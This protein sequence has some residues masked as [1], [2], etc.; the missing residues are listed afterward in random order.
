MPAGRPT[1]S[2]ESAATIAAKAAKKRTA[3]AEAESQ[4]AAK[5]M[6]FFTPRTRSSA[7]SAAAS[8]GTSSRSSA[9]AS[10]S[11]VLG[12]DDSKP[13][14]LP[15]SIAGTGGAGA[16]LAADT[17]VPSLPPSMLGNSSAAASSSSAPGA[18]DGAPPTLPSPIAGAGGAGAG[19]ADINM[20]VQNEEALGGLRVQ[21]NELVEQQNAVLEQAPAP[22]DAPSIP[23]VPAA[24][25]TPETP[26]APL[27]PVDAD[28]DPETAEDTPMRTYLRLV[29]QRLMKE[30]SAKSG[31]T[32]KWL[33]KL[34]D[35]NDW[36][37]RAEHALHVCSKLGIKEPAERFYYYSVYVWLPDVRWGAVPSCLCGCDR[38]NVISHGFRTGALRRGNDEWGGR[39]HENSINLPYF[40]TS[41]Q[42]FRV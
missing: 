7:N 22:A 12:M 20:V 11:S 30:M 9:T 24:P 37:L 39:R 1:G 29:N 3:Q 10:S 15:L 18:G 38:K 14:V 6:N 41:Q 13:P 5:K 32:D 31:W 16:G 21:R 36:W 4:R 27:E 34:L 35:H 26:E 19:L 40:F 25:A 2:K 23:A 33:K 17:S 28:T 8:L 42:H